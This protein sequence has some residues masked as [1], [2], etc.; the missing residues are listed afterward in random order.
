VAREGD[1]NL[2]PC[3]LGVLAVALRQPGS[4]Q[5]IL[6]EHA[7]EYVKVLADF[8]MIAQ[9]RSHMSET[10]AYMEDFLKRFH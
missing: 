7:L 9:Y 6:F 3:I 8:N 2:E 1:G 4:A 5:V 10:I